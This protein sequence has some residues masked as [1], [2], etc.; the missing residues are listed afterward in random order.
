MTDR[1][2]CTEFRPDR[3]RQRDRLMLVNQLE[4]VVVVVVV[5]DN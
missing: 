1:N 4:N 3:D 5:V 2:I